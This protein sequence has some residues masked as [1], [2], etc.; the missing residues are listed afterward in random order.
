MQEGAHFYPFV[1]KKHEALQVPVGYGGLTS[2]SARCPKTRSKIP[3]LLHHKSTHRSIRGLPTSV[4]LVF[5]LASWCH[6]NRLPKDANQ[7]LCRLLFPPMS[8][9]LSTSTSISARRSELG[10]ATNDKK[11]SIDVPQDRLDASVLACF[12]SS[13]VSANSACQSREGRVRGH[14][15][16]PASRSFC[17]HGGH[18]W[19]HCLFSVERQSGGD[20]SR[21]I[22]SEIWWRLGLETVCSASFKVHHPFRS[23]SISQGLQVALDFVEVGRRSSIASEMWHDR[24][25]GQNG[26]V[27]KKKKKPGTSVRA[28]ADTTPPDP[29]VKRKK[30]GTP[31]PFAHR[32]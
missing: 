25:I 10:A 22:S 16:L 6:R 15:I 13:G 14:G 32:T 31:S 2:H 5:P 23:K 12:P 4:S 26:V 30:R 24:L 17:G 11:K 27:K 1:G 18:L 28:T 21:E 20:G 19:R 29:S 7:S 3:G 8:L 9:L